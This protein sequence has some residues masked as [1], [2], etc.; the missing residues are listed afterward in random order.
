MEGHKTKAEG[1][2]AG[3]LR[4][5]WLDSR[6]AVWSDACWRAKTQADSWGGTQNARR[7]RVVPMERG[8]EPSR[9]G[10]RSEGVG[11]EDLL[12][13]CALE[14]RVVEAI[15]HG[16]YT[17]S[18]QQRQRLATALGV[19]TGADLLGAYGNGRTHPRA[20]AAGSA[21]AR[22]FSRGADMDSPNIAVLCEQHRN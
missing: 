22:E 11:L 9:S 21:E 17:P 14:R 3:L 7:G 15:V 16:R 1:F 5:E 10:W 4:Q 20:W 6:S 18:P 8:Q 13:S 19:R 2:P 12:R